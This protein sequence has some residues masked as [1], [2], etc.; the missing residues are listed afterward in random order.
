LVTQETR[1]SADAD[2]RLDVFSGQSRSTNNL[3]SLRRFAKHVIG[4]THYR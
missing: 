1:I 3:G 2:N 4:N